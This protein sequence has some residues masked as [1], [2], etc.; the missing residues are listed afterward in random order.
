MPEITTRL[1]V[2]DPRRERV[3]R[4]LVQMEP[5]LDRPVLD[6]VVIR[7]VILLKH[8]TDV[9]CGI[10]GDLWT[11]TIHVQTT[12]CFC[13]LPRHNSVLSLVVRVKARLRPTR[14]AS[15]QT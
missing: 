3:Y 6:Q 15:R 12:P 9:A 14:T 2:P 1:A 4:F 13:H 7:V 8:V 5:Q 11:E 10:G